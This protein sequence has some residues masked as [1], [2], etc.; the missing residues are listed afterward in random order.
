MSARRL[1]RRLNPMRITF[2][3]RNHHLDPVAPSYESAELSSPWK[4]ESTLASRWG[5]SDEGRRCTRWQCCSVQGR[6]ASVA[7]TVFAQAVR[8]HGP[9]RVGSGRVVG[10][11]SYPPARASVHSRFMQCPL[12]TAR[13]CTYSRERG[14]FRFRE[15]R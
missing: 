13:S 14:V 15:D 12:M 4:G 2:F 9:G 1:V 3:V 11:V 8:H 5:A 10:V 6:V 7:T